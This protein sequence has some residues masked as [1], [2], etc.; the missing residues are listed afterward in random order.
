LEIKQRNVNGCEW[1]QTNQNGCQNINFFAIF[2]TFCLCDA[3]LV[4][5]ESWNL[6]LLDNMDIENFKMNQTKF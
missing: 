3:T 4:A 1:V 2:V 5:C 6:C